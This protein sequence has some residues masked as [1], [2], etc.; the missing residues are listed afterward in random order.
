MSELLVPVISPEG[1]S[2]SNKS[3]PTL[4]HAVPCSS[5]GP[6]ASYYGTVDLC[7]FLTVSSTKIHDGQ[8]PQLLLYQLHHQ[9]Q[10]KLENIVNTH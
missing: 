10:G 4:I 8:L 6:K 7:F 9:H 1:L 5:I 3:V 2:D